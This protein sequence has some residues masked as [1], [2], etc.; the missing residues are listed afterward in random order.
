VS[1]PD[2]LSTE[3]DQ[4]KEDSGAAVQEIA[5]RSML[6]GV[7]W[8]GSSILE[9][10]NGLA[11][12]RQQERLNDVFDALKNRLQELGKEKI[13]RGFFKSE[14][15]QTLL[16]LVI[17]RLHTTHDRTKLAMCGIAL[18]NSANTDFKEDHREL[19][20]RALRIWPSRIYAL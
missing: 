3:I 5:L 11:Q 19:F 9:M 2:E 13:D 7:P 12:R 6:A 8:L 14:E 15:F 17:E 20:V 1:L 4:Y 18:A 10:L 16:F